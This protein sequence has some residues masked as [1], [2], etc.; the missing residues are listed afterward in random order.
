[1]SA[2]LQAQRC[3]VRLQAVAFA[4]SKRA[5]LHCVC[6]L[7]WHNHLGLT[8][9]RMSQDLT[10][11]AADSTSACLLHRNLTSVRIV[12]MMNLHPTVTKFQAFLFLQSVF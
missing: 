9:I 7:F 5:K 10:I 8:L 11:L 6:K 2:S 12:D 3:R 1:M 4:S